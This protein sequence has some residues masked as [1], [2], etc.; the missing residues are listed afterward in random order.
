MLNKNIIKIKLL[1]RNTN[2][3]GIPIAPAFIHNTLYEKAS[4]TIKELM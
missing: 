2:M 3:H 4:Q 1:L